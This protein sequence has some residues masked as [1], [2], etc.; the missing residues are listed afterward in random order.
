[1]DSQRQ[2]DA[3]LLIKKMPKN[4]KTELDSGS[5]VGIKGLAFIDYLKTKVLESC[6]GSNAVSCADIL[7]LAA[8]DAYVLVSVHSFIGYQVSHSICYM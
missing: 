6:N 1:M 3:S 2:C 4:E 7:A 5:N 8:R